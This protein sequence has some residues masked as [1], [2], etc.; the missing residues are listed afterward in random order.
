[1]SALPEQPDFLVARNVVATGPNLWWQTQGQAFGLDKPLQI[2]HPDAIKQVAEAIQL[3]L[4]Q[5][6]V[7]LPSGFDQKV[8]IETATFV[9]LC[10]E[11]GHGAL[12]VSHVNNELNED[13]ARLKGAKRTL[14]ENNSQKAEYQ[15]KYD[16]VNSIDELK[17]E[18]VGVKLFLQML[19][20]RTAP[21]E[22][23]VQGNERV[24]QEQYC[25]ALLGT[26][27][28]YLQKSSSGSQRRYYFTSQILL[29]QL[30]ESGA[31]T[32][33]DQQF[34]IADPNLMLQTIDGVADKILAIYADSSANLEKVVDSFA[35]LMPSQQISL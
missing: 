6:Y 28:D 14:A 8:F 12:P 10:H 13:E 1:M 32:R 30:L 20:Q 5:K 33:N 23:G 2:I 19:R 16:V 31:L 25:I 4:I 7:E 17:A 34:K 22:G 26:L 21:D 24:N 18:A 15:E 9:T 29:H 3:P 27:F 11:A 35:E